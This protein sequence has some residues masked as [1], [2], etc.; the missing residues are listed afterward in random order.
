[1]TPVSPRGF[2]PAAHDADRQRADAEGIIREVHGYCWR[3]CPLRE[4]CPGMECRQYRREQAAKDVLATLDGSPPDVAIGPA[5]V[6][7]T[8]QIGR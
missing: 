8:P 6:V 2:D 1:M 7:L 5:G 4:R 3:Q